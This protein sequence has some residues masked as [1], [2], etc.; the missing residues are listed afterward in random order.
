MREFQ[1]AA[2]VIRVEMVR[3][4]YTSESLCE[5]TEIS[6]TVLRDILTGRKTSISTRNICAMARAF[7][8]SASEFIDLLSGAVDFPAYTNE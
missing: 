1:N 6:S 5:A 7:G 8:F 3:C 4:G 2:S